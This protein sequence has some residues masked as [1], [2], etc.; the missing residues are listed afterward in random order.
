MK[1]SKYR[2]KLRICA[3]IL[4]IIGERGETGPTRILYGANLSYDRLVKYL[5]YL[6]GLSLIEEVRV[7]EEKTVYR[8]TK[9]G[10][11]FLREYRRVERFARAFGIEL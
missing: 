4:R 7:G 2:S 5:E 10:V 9:K 3:D 1:G 11:E 8:L 6:K